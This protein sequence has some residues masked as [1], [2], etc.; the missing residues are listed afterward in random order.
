[1]RFRRGFRARRRRA[2]V[3][4]IDGVPGF[5][6]A[7]NSQSTLVTMS[8]LGSAAPYTNIQS[9]AIRLVNSTDLSE[10]GGEDAVFMR[11]R[12]RILLFNARQGVGGTPAVVAGGFALRIVIAQTEVI[13]ETSGTVSPTPFVDSSGMG[14]DSILWYHD[15]L[16]SGSN[17]FLSGGTGTAEASTMNDNWIDIDVKAKR[18]VQKDREIFMWF[19][20]MIAGLTPDLDFRL[21]GGLRM[22]MK[23]PR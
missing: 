23:R 6:L 20:T 15:T 17:V 21:V 14:R 5:S 7:G 18:R 1:M 11:A 2:S 9:A 16:V 22:L 13:D 19:Q 4:W 3:A 8:P 12:G 10:H